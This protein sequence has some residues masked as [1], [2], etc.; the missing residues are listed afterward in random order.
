MLEEHFRIVFI[1]YFIIDVVL[2]ISFM[3]LCMRMYNV[4]L[5]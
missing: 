2:L 4:M 3:L 5:F 1:R